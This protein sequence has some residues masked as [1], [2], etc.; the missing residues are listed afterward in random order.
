MKTTFPIRKSKGFTLVELLVVIAIIIT[1]AGISM[2]VIQGVRAKAS[3]TQAK[4]Q[5]SDLKQAV[6]NYMLDH[7]GLPP[8]VLSPKEN[9]RATEQGQIELTTAIDDSSKMM[10][11]LTNYMDGSRDF[12]NKNTKKKTYFNATTTDEDN[13]PGLHFADKGRVGLLDPWGAPYYVI[14]STESMDSPRIHVGT[15]MVPSSSA[16]YSTGKDLSGSTADGQINNPD[17]TE[18]NITTFGKK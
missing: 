6:D 2:L 11:I 5:A 3:E 18:D 14:I 15:K 8:A 1:L 4:S 17:K 16:V 12:K 9:R 10:A 7:A 13:Q